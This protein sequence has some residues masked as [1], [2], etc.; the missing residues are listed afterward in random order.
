MQ[1]PLHDSAS[2]ANPSA[3]RNAGPRRPAPHRGGAIAPPRTGR[4]RPLRNG[5]CHPRTYAFA[6][7]LLLLCSP[8]A[9]AVEP[10]EMLADPTLEARAQALDEDIRC[11]R[12]RSENIAS[13]NADWARDA[14]LIVREMISDGASDAEILDFFVERY[15]ERVLMRPRSDGANVVLWAAGPV[16]LV[17]SALIA[18]AY[19]RARARTNRRAPAPLSKA[20]QARLNDILNR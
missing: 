5:V 7:I 15:G 9:M 6:L 11:V 13:S 3:R 8:P 4:T 14:R 18:A 17:L 16:M 1:R 19:L 2:A 12:C 10:D 20:E